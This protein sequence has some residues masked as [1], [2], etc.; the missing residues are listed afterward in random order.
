MNDNLSAIQQVL[1]SRGDAVARFE[2][3]TFFAMMLSAS[4][5]GP[6]LMETSRA[7]FN[8]TD[9]TLAGTAA[10]VNA[11]AVA[12]GR[13]A[14]RKMKTKDG[15]FINVPPSILLCGPDKEFEAQQLLAPIAAAQASNVNPFSGSLRL[16][17]SAQITGNAWYLF[18]DPSA[19]ANFEWGLLEGYTAPRLRTDEPFGTQGMRLSLEH[20]FGCG[21]INFRGGYRN[22]G[23]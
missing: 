17:V 4:G 6:T 11:A 15:T 18:A 5:A 14:M 13:A 19:V 3:E 7:V 12:L 8:T 23:A 10:A 2:E 20:D 22:A 16:V 1:N 21:A 9:G